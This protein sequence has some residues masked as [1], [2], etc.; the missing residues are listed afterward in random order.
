[1]VDIILEIIRALI[2]AG[3]VIYFMRTD[4]HIEHGRRGW[5]FIKLGF[6]CFLFGSIIDI[7]DNFPS[8]SPAIIIGNTSFQAFL[9]EFVGYL[10]GFILLF[11]GLWIWLPAMN[12]FGNLETELNEG[13]R[14]LEELA[15]DK[16]AGIEREIENRRNLEISLRIAEEMRALIYD[17][18]P[19]GIAHGLI[20]GSLLERNQEFASM[21]GYDSPEEMTEIALD[22]GNGFIWHDKNDL[23]SVIEMLK[24]EKHLRGLEIRFDHKNGSIVWALLD[25]TT[26][27]D[28]RGINYY[29]YCFAK[30]ITE[31]KLAVQQVAESEQRL[32]TLM[33]AMHTGIY[34]VDIAEHTIK[35]ANPAT[36]EMTGY[37]LEDL[38][39]MDCC[40]TLCANEKKICT[41]L[42]GETAINNGE[43]RIKRK[44]GSSFPVIK[45]VARVSMGE[46]EYLLETFVDISE[47]KRLEQ[48]KEDVDRI[49][50]HDLKSPV[51]GVI[52]ASSVALMDESI[53][54]EAREMIEAIHRQG[55]KILRMVGLSLAIYKMEAGVY[56]YEAEPQDLIAEVRDVL[57]DVTDS[58]RIRG[59]TIET[60][61]DGTTMEAD[62]SL[63][64]PGNG[65]LVHS[66]LGNLLTNAIEAS[67]MGQ[68][69]S[70]DIK[71]G[72]TIALKITNRG[73]VP[74]E[75]REKFFEK[76]ATAG[77]SHGTGLGTYSADLI[78]KT[79]GGSIEMSTS[80]EENM[81]EV[82][83]RL[84]GFME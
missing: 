15:Q 51:V 55:N 46:R 16:S 2:L 60:A 38:V 12:S 39:D 83:I 34:L 1:M 48:L 23:Q 72:M 3:I 58:S 24:K 66:L 61:V 9:E 40:E 73:A 74:E 77:K 22:K 59:V 47:Q 7:T 14:A 11:T 75:V 52:N 29:F 62:T 41:C 79:M 53:Q 69:V 5:L 81:T 76:Y 57:A 19:V 25:F 67:D 65:V 68:T 4:K 18:A 32:K 31:Q 26:L 64:F 10:G 27:A 30:D 6:L 45:T 8:L 71:S 54:G 84:P 13:K 78:A 20:G 70:L 36:L 50:S 37:S 33:N 35:D 63:I 49:V 28:R 80:D 21:L 42:G 44:D 17:N 56:E 43:A 82:T